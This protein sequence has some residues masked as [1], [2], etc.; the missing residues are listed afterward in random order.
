M[1]K[2]ETVSVLL[3]VEVG[4]DE[5]GEPIVNYDPSG[6]V[7]VIVAPGSTSDVFGNVRDGQKVALTLHFPKTWTDNLTGARV[8]VRGDEYRVVGSPFRYTDSPGL[9]DMPV[10]VTACNG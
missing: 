3:P 10:E 5:L 1:I 9:Y 4:S 6:S 2:P 8:I 7:D